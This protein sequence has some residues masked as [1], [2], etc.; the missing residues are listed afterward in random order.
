MSS[1]I[2]ILIMLLLSITTMVAENPSSANYILEQGSFGSG[3]DPANPPISANYI[4]Q[5]SIIGVISGEETA[6]ANYNMLPGYYLGEI[7]GGILAPDSVT[8][9]VTGTQ[10]QLSWNAV[11]GATSYKVYSSN[12]PYSGFEEDN[13]G[14]FTGESWN[15]SI[16]TVKKFYYVKA[17]D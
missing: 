3:S 1:K 7:T 14:T 2:Y 5:G 10:V 11:S 13:T 8:V 12:D 4:L 17:V 6:S 15:A 16:S 9:V